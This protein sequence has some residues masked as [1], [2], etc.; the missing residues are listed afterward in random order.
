MLT[1]PDPWHALRLSDEDVAALMQAVDV[2]W[3]SEDS[4]A[5]FPLRS[6]MNVRVLLARGDVVKNIDSF[7]PPLRDM[8]S[9]LDAVLAKLASSASVDQR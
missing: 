3:V 2:L 7:G 1:M 9:L 6:S 4:Y 5:N 8:R